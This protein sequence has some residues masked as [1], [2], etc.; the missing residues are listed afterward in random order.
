MTIIDY[1][2]AAGKLRMR[3]GDIS[4]LPFLPDSVYEAVYTENGNNLQRSVI[5]CGSMILAQLSFKTHRK[6][7]QLEVYGAEAFENYRSFLML[8]IKDPAYMSVSPIPYS[9]SGTALHPLLQ[10]ANDWNKGFPITDSQQLAHNASI[11]VNDGS[12]YGV[13]GNGD[14]SGW[15]LTSPLP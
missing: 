2:T 3:L 5:A 10:F 9:A 6:L 14:A 4:S 12:L 11:S 1:S 7:A 15:T 8:T 13:L